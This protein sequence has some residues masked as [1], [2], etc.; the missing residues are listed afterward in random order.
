V[1]TFSENGLAP[2]GLAVGMD[3]WVQAVTTKAAMQNNKL[4]FI[5]KLWLLGLFSQTYEEFSHESGGG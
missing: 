1:A 2:V 4:V 5:G 3:L